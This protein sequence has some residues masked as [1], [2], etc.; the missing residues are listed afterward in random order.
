MEDDEIKTFGERII[1]GKPKD[2]SDNKEQN[3]FGM[4]EANFFS[5]PE[6][7]KDTPPDGKKSQTKK[8]TGGLSS[9]EDMDTLKKMGQNI[10]GY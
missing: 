9:E 8:S 4:P 6:F 10:M 1:G 7:G 5:A 3:F 2:K